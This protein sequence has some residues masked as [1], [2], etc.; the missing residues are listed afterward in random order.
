MISAIY[1]VAEIFS[2][3]IYWIELD[4]KTGV[5]RTLAVAM[6]HYK[7]RKISYWFKLVFLDFN[8]YFFLALCVE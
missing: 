7:V 4:R 3:R 1:Q 2:D 5:I 6:K 8:D